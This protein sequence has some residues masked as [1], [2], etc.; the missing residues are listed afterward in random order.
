[1]T[2]LYIGDNQTISCADMDQLLAGGDIRVSEY[3]GDGYWL[4]A[5]KGQVTYFTTVQWEETYEQAAGRF[6]THVLPMLS[7][8]AL[9][10]GLKDDELRI[11]FFFDN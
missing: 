4:R 2:N 3:V 11:V 7:A 5:P 8:Y 9:A 1:M 6:S 10:Q